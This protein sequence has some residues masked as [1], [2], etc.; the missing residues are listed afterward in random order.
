LTNATSNIVCDFLKT[1]EGNHHFYPKYC[2]IGINKIK[3][4]K[5]SLPSK[6]R[7]FLLAIFVALFCLSSVQCTY[8]PDWDRCERPSISPIFVVYNMTFNDV[9][10]PGKNITARFCGKGLTYFKATIQKISI[11]S[12]TAF[13]TVLPFD[14][15]FDWLYLICFDVKFKIP[16]TSPQ[17][18]PINFNFFTV[19][20]EE[21]RNL[22]C[23][24]TAASKVAAVGVNKFLSS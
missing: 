15:P 23:I 6:M 16:E 9:P 20:N 4:P 22:A 2:L 11:S 19:Y 14:I 5:K 18:S 13:E 21:D 3:T 1:W 8:E 10:A 17:S 24:T 7:T 12:G